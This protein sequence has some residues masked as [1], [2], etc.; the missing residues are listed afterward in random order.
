MNQ[1]DYQSGGY[2]A[3]QNDLVLARLQE[4]PGEWVSLPVL[5]SASGAYAVHSRISDLRKLGHRIEQKSVGQ[6]MSFNGRRAV[7]SFYRLVVFL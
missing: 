2:G 1:Q 3:T 6:A 5:I 4:C 7:L